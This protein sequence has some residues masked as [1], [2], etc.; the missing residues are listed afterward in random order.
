M[1]QKHPQE[2]SCRHR[3]TSRQR[4]AGD[5]ADQSLDPHHPWSADRGGCR[6]K[7]AAAG[8]RTNLESRRGEILRHDLPCCLGFLP[9]GRGQPAAKEQPSQQ[10]RNCP[11]PPAHLHTPEKGRWTSNKCVGTARPDAHGK[12]DYTRPA[13]E[14]QPPEKLAKKRAAKIGRFGIP[15]RVRY[16]RSSPAC[17]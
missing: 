4:H 15:G 2:L 17:Q 12:A 8:T 16:S 7:N 14:R 1:P 5:D 11:N 6:E 13:G 9:L 10:T 3:R